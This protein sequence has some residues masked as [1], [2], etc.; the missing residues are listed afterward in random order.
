M[1]RP[2]ILWICTDQQRLDTLGVYGNPY[3]KTPNIDRLAQSGVLFENCFGQ[4]PVCTPSRASFLTGRYPRTTRTRQN[5]QSIPPD[6]VLVTKLLAEAG[7]R[8]G[9]SGKLHLSACNPK[10]SLATERRIDDGY[11]TFY[12]SHHP[13]ADWP[14][15]QY[16]NWL[17]EQGLTFK[18]T[19]YRGSQF[20]QTSLP[21]EYHQTT[22]CVDRALDFIKEASQAGENWLFSLN[23][24]DPHHPFS[25]PQDYLERYLPVLDELPLPN[26][27][28]GELANKPIFQQMDHRGAYNQPSLYPFDQMNEQ[29]HRLIKAAYWAM[30]DLIDEQVG[31]LITLL[32]KTGQ[33]ENTLV[34]FMTDHGE[35][36]GDH[37]IYLK[38]PYFYEPA[39][40]LPLVISWPGVIRQGGRHDNLVELVDIAPTLLEAVG[41]PVYEGMQGVSL[42]PTLTGQEDG[43]ASRDYVYSEYYNAMPWHKDPLPFATMVRSNRYKLVNFHG[44]N[45]GELYDLETDPLERNNLWNDPSYLGVQLEMFRLLADSQAKTVDPLPLRQ[46]PW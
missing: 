28:E 29:D 40:H 27:A 20:V 4:S 1:K 22:W 17:A 16:T 26:Y 24:Y 15:N 45:M 11:E 19:P 9:L 37:G 43:Q 6:E 30:V 8:C 10:V 25:P 18:R 13:D 35:M 34:I 33:L 39:I 23:V 12:W 44:L 36:L 42:W 7:Y 2:N 41:L 14:T 5:G 3:V 46:G 31:R 21:A 38:G 32:E